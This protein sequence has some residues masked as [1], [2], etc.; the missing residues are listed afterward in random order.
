MLDAG[1][2]RLQ[3]VVIGLRHW[4][5]LMIVAP[6]AANRQAEKRA[7]RRAHHVVQFIRALRRRQ[8]RVRAFYL[9][10]RPAHQKTHGGVLAEKVARE[11]LEDEALVRLVLVQRAD[12]IVAIPPGGRAR[13]VHLEAVGFGEAHDIQP[14][15]R[16]PLTVMRRR[17]Q[18]FDD[19]L[20][21]IGGPVSLKSPHLGR[22]RRQPDKVEV[23]PPNQRPPRRL[24]RRREFGL[25]QFGEDK[26]VNRIA[27]PPFQIRY[28]RHVRTGYW[29]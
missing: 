20:V 6:R 14:M 18:A 22:R 3:R 24:R 11:L 12:D 19:F 23:K 15:L 28:S 27:P 29:L 1:Q 7:A 25:R 4:V 26:I 10:P 2:A 5:E 17:Q 9:V 8:H 13:L 16:P 21:S